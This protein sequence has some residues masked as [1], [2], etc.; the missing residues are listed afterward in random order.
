MNN[1]ASMTSYS[2]ETWEKHVLVNMS[3]KI[4]CNWA[5]KQSNL[6]FKF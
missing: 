2:Q 4:N 1:G 6:N 3:F 5:E